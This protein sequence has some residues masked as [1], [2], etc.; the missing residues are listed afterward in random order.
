MNSPE[1]KRASMV[2]LLGGV[3]A[4]ST[5]WLMAAPQSQ[6]GPA[7]TFDRDIAP[8]MFRSCAMCHRP[9]EAGPFLLLTYS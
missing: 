7:V 3:S 2:V 1:C 4:L 8:I 6:T 5:L 9:G